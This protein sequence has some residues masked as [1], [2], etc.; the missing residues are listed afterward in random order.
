MEGPV[1]AIVREYSDTDSDVTVRSTVYDSVTFVRGFGDNGYRVETVEHDCPECQ[2]DRMIR[3][4]DVSPEMAD[5]VRYFCLN[6]N[7]VHFVR[8]E[9]S[10][11]CK[12]SYPQRQTSEPEIFE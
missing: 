7:C 3:R 8:T 11:A 1:P 6:P 2:F 12:G 4:H 10:H 5:E 9:L